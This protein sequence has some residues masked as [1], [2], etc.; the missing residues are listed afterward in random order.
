MKSLLTTLALLMMPTLASATC[1]Q[2]SFVDTFFE[3]P[4]QSRAAIVQ[5]TPQSIAKGDTTLDRSGLMFLSN[6][7][8]Q[9]RGERGDVNGITIPDTAFSL[10]AD[11]VVV[12]YRSPNGMRI[13]N[14]FT[15]LNGT[16]TLTIQQICQSGDTTTCG[17]LSFDWLD[18]KTPRLAIAQVDN[19]DG[20]TWTIS[21]DSCQQTITDSFSM[22]DYTRIQ[23][24]D[25]S[26]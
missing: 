23:N 19:N 12:A 25:Y 7:W 11:L 6:K 9:A 3:W 14:T 24:A 17:A 15:T 16:Q 4:A 13:G 8:L 1:A 5:I 26:N 20:I 22:E 10:T 21:V 2:K 18:T